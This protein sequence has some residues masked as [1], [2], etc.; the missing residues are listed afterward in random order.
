MKIYTK[1]G[2]KGETSLFGGRRVPKDALRI[3]AFGTVD[4]LNSALGLCRALNPRRETGKILEQ[5][6]RDL[7][8]LGAELAT[9]VLAGKTRPA[10][11]GAQDAARLERHIDLL[12]ARERGRCAGAPARL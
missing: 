7:F 6:Q 3:E 2:D 11:I 12:G 9:P 4:E 1:T 8:S 5:I 10:R